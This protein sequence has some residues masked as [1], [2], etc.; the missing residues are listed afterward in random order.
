LADLYPDPAEVGGRLMTMW[1]QVVEL[2][3]EVPAGVWV[4][5]AVANMVLTAA[6]WSAA[7]RRMRRAGQ[8]ATDPRL[9]TRAARA[10]DAALTVAA[11][12]PAGLFWM[13]VMAGSFHGLVA[14]GRDM[15]GWRDGWEYLV[16]GTLDGV[17]VTFAFLAFRAV[18][19]HKPP[20]RCRRVVWGAAVASATVNFAYEYSDSGHNLV[21]GGYLALLSLFGMVMF[22]EFL[23]QFEDG[24]G[25]VRRKN[26]AFG[27][28]WLTW[29]TN[30]FCA[31]VAWQNHPP[32]EDTPATVRNAVANLDRVRAV[33][34]QGREVAT[35]QRHQQAIAQAQR[36]AEIAA[37][38]AGRRP[39]QDAAVASPASS[40]RRH[41][42]EPQPIAPVDPP[43]TTVPSPAAVPGQP[44]DRTGPRPPRPTTA[45]T[46]TTEVRV[47]ATA[48]TL[49]QWAQTWIKMCSD[50][51]TA[52]GPLNDDTRARADYGL[53]AK[54]LR[55]IRNAATTSALRRRAAE[56]G[57]ELPT[58]Y[59][60]QPTNNRHNG[61]PVSAAAA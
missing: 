41:D 61:H 30:T 24:T 29:P 9:V 34:H 3:D 27:L 46:S 37:T 1:E 22:H 60:D 45:P 39:A 56:L 14:F 59:R 49:T 12:V 28:R 36:K 7:R 51:D 38:S 15:L 53:S 8:R 47:P 2:V 31:A 19:K 35:A 4:G 13:M 21:A 17:S 10:K 25:Q 23:D 11:M 48:A 5:L 58:D 16:P 55:N 44:P 18:G 32:A 54:Q 26:P 6:T 43:A 50:G 57:V 33:K 52:T 20:D 42:S 40:G